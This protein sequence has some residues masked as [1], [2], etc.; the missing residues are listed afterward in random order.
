M[1]LL[2]NSPL[3]KFINN[4][5]HHHLARKDNTSYSHRIISQIIRD[6]GYQVIDEYEIDNKVFDMYLPEKNLCIEYNG[7]THYLNGTNVMI[8][9][10]N[11][12]LRL[13]DKDIDLL[14]IPFFETQAYPEIES[15]VYYRNDEFRDKSEQSKQPTLKKYLQNLLDNVDEYKVKI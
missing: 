11:Y 14:Y 7:P 5:L 2:K 4:N 12:K 10:D 15:S 3:E 8:G 6:L 1:R 13:V 9:S